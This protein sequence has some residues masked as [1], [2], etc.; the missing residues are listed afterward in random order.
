MEHLSL[1][2]GNDNPFSTGL[3]AFLTYI[4]D[5]QMQYRMAIADEK[6]AN[7]STQDILHSVELDE[8]EDWDLLRLIKVLRTIRNNRREAKNRIAQLQPIVD[9]I[10]QNKQVINQL[11]K[12]L[13]MMRKEEK[14]V[15]TRLYARR[16]TVLDHIQD[17][18]EDPDKDQK[19]RC[20]LDL[21]GSFEAISIPE[22]G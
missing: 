18:F 2:R 22:E 11:D 7:D 12:I 1:E 6:E 14:R 8:N 15:F 9:W 19:D 13:G 5:C 3:D 21:D 4:R 17:Y 10:D 16:S 20:L